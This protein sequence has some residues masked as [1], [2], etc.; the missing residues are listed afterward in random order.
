M[1]I[2]NFHPVQAFAFHT[3]TFCFNFKEEELQCYIF[4]FGYFDLPF[5]LAFTW[6]M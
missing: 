2:F 6:I 3:I 4:S 1:A 5:T